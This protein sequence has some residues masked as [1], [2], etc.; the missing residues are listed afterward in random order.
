MSLL[1]WTALLL[2]GAGDAS[3]N[4]WRRLHAQGADVGYLD[5]DLRAA[6]AE[7]HPKVL[8]EARRKSLPPAGAPA[9]DWT[10]VVRGAP[11]RNQYG[12]TCCWAYAAVGALEWSWA[13]RN[14]QAPPELAVQPLLDRVGKDGTGYAGWALKELLEHGTCPAVNYPHV[15]RPAVLRA[16][17]RTPYRAVEW[18]LVEPRGGVPEAALLKQ[19]LLDFGPVV[20]NIYGTDAFNAYRG[21]VFSERA[22]IPADRPTSHILLIVGWDDRKGQGGCWKVQNSAG[23]RWG[24]GGFGWVEYGCNNVG[25]SAC[26]VRAQATHYQLPA[27]AHELLS[28]GAAPFPSW[29]GAEVVKLPLATEAKAIDPAQAVQMQGQR[30]TVQFR[31]RGGGIKPSEGHV[32]LFSQPS[33][34]DEG[35]LIVTIP[36]DEL[37][38]F[39]GGGDKGV[40]EHYVGRQ[41]R[42]RGSVQPKHIFFM[43]KPNPTYVGNRPILEVFSPNQMDIVD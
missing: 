21:G 29:P 16:R 26:W 27:S 28:A 5:G 38:K 40:L 22:A 7:S 18:G 31:V 20:A 2:P 43:T 19:A 13:I 25:H 10:E 9:F 42:V 12:S 3:G 17:V 23:R 36:K 15:G 6:F 1:L 34:R 24:Q 30:V 32:E 4:V 11:V 35:C 33:W 39:P 37:G 14:G 41:V 8:P